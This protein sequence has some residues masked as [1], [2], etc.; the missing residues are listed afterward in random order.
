MFDSQK[1]QTCWKET[2]V[3]WLALDL[4]AKELPRYAKCMSNIRSTW[5]AYCHEI[6]ITLTVTL[7]KVG[8]MTY[9]SWYVMIC[10]DMSWYVMCHAVYF[11]VVKKRTQRESSM[12]SIPALRSNA[13]LERVRWGHCLRW[14]ETLRTD[15]CLWSADDW[16]H[17]QLLM[18]NISS[19]IMKIC[20]GFMK[21]IYEGFRPPRKVLLFDFDSTELEVAWKVKHCA[22]K[23]M[24]SAHSV[25]KTMNELKTDETS[26]QQSWL[27]SQNSITIIV[28]TMST[29]IIINTILLVISSSQATG[30]ATSSAECEIILI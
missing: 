19:K 22:M 9:M 6:I 27:S 30:L 24:C 25:G 20:Q 13:K 21:Q 10:H 28:M 4:E 8:T 2:P 17:Q 3:E 26:W 29:I 14:K 18:T 1:L 7:L 16:P 15:T 23:L 5:N 11:S 12:I